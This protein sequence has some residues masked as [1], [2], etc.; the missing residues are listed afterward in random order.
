[1]RAEMR[2]DCDVIMIGEI[3]DIVDLPDA[4]RDRDAAAL[5]LLSHAVGERDPHALAVRVASFLVREFGVPLCGVTWSDGGETCGAVATALTAAATDMHLARFFPDGAP[6][7]FSIVRSVTRALPAECESRWASGPPASRGEAP[8]GSEVGLFWLGRTA[9]LRAALDRAGETLAAALDRAVELRALE[10]LATTDS[11][12]DL[13]NRRGFTAM[14]AH[15]CARAA[16]HGGAVTLA[17]VDL[18][19]FKP[20]NDSFGH[21]EGDRVLRAAAGTI[22]AALRTADIVARIGGDEFAIILPDTGA[23]Q[24]QIA[25]ARVLAALA[26]V[27]AGGRSLAA[28]IGLAEL[29]P[30]RDTP[31]TLFDAADRAL[32]GSKRIGGGRVTPALGYKKV[33]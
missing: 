5:Q 11:L 8:G 2:Q 6:E 21:S 32:Y 29:G 22:R 17:L 4:L 16:R 10:R 27:T 24:A 28:S 15:E 20:I 9:E 12:T 30:S 3:L 25:M 13:H 7:R 31:E 1:M 33:E 19:G 18:D 26:C 14:L 23:A